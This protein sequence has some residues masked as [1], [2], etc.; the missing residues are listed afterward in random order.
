[1]PGRGRMPLVAPAGGLAVSR[2]RTAPHPLAVL[3]LDDSL[4]H[5]VDHHSTVTTRNRAIWSFV[6]NLP[7]ALSVARTRFMGFVEPRLLVSTSCTP[8]DSST[9]RTV[10]PAMTPVPG[11]AGIS[12]TRAAP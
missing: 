2:P 8:A 7:S 11:S 12:T 6:L 5:F 4:V 9:A 1:M 3:P 10:F